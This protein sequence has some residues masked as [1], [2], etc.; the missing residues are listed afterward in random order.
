MDNESLFPPTPQILHTQTGVAYYGSLPEEYRLATID[1]F[2]DNGKRK[3]G[4]PF[5]IQWASAANVFQICEVKM[6]LTSA[7]LYPFLAADSVFVLKQY[8]LS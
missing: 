5:L 2:L 8:P 4:M 6:S 3:V 7:I 1:D